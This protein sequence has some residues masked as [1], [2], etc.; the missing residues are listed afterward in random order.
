MPSEQPILLIP[1][2]EDSERDAVA[3]AW[4]GRGWPVQ[5]LDRFWQP[6]ALDRRQV[7]VYG[8]ELFCL[9]LAQKLRL[10]LV[11]P[12]DDLLG[13]VDACW[14]KRG[15]R[16]ARLAEAAHLSYPLFVKPATPKLFRAAV[17]PDHAALAAE[18]RGLEP[19]TAIIT[20]EPVTFAAEAR[21]LVLRR[22]VVSVAVYEGS[23]SPDVARD[24]AQ[25]FVSANALPITCALDVGLIRGRG[26][27]VIE[28]NPVWGAGLN[29]CSPEA[30]VDC[31]LV[32][33]I[34]PAS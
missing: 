18:T 27:A 1:A 13:R 4:V 22:G 33:T 31:L 32:A 23:A 3:A 6:P 20:A 28:A 15:L 21:C 29:G 24:F 9:T 25:A 12:P 14:L 2:R 16:A 34:P 11:S 26:W 30:M 10:G 7:R 8:N 19:I 17:Y 5:R